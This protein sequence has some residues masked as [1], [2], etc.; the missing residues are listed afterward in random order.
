[1][2]D[3]YANFAEL[4]RSER[5]GVDFRICCTRREL[6]VAIIAPHGGKIEPATSQIASAIAGA[7]YSVY[8]FEGMKPSGNSALHITSENFDEPRCVELVSTSDYVVTVHG[9]S[10]TNEAIDV[11]GLDQALRDSICACLVGGGFTAQVIESG[12][13]A[14][15]D[16]RNICNRGSRGAGVQLEISRGLRDALTGQPLRMADFASAVRSAIVGE[17]GEQGSSPRQGRPG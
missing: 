16:P 6:G 10:G 8:C 4:S 5:E 7:E 1:M 17:I 12:A 11:G 9:L 3:R 15:I 14:G 2:A 13:H